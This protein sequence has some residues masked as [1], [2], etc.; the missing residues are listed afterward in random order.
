MTKYEKTNLWV[1][2][3]ENSSAGSKFYK[4]CIDESLRE[5]LPEL[6]S[7]FRKNET[8]I[9]ILARFILEISG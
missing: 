4:K 2:D 9:D 7:T 6:Q 5:A 1:F 8:I 3:E